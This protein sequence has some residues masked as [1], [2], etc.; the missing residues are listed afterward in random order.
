MV[1]DVYWSAVGAAFG[2]V[3]GAAG[4]GVESGMR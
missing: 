4:M 2:L 3:A 1:L